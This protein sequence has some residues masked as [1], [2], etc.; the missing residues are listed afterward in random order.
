M[1]EKATCQW[2]S[3]GRAPEAFV[4]VLQGRG[5]GGV[6]VMEEAD[7]LGTPARGFV[8]DSRKKTQ[9]VCMANLGLRHTMHIT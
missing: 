9:G 1:R 6:L 4:C 2:P 5:G 7:S 8:T 3:L